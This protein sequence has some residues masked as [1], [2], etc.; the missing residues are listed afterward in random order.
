MAQKFTIPELAAA[1]RRREPRLAGVDDYALAKMVLERRPDLLQVLE[2]SEPRRPLGSLYERIGGRLK[3]DLNLP[4]QAQGA[5]QAIHQGLVNI[6]EHGPSQMPAFL[7]ALKQYA[8]PENAIGDILAS[9]I[10]GQGGDVAPRSSGNA[11]LRTPAMG[12][13]FMDM[14]TRRGPG[15]TTAPSTAPNY[16]LLDNLRMRFERQKAAEDPGM[17]DTGAKIREVEDQIKTA[18]QSQWGQAYQKLG[19]QTEAGLNFSA[20]DLEALKKKYGIG[21]V[22]PPSK[23][24]TSV[25]SYLGEN[26]PASMTSGGQVIEQAFGPKTIYPSLRAWVESH[27][28]KVRDV[29]GGGGWE[30][31]IPWTNREAGTK[32][33]TWEKFTNMEEARRALG[34]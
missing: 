17:W 10:M 30:V 20:G 24:G 33:S 14:S 7:Q 31:E 27:G 25:G 1:V 34:Y 8:K 6:R 5:A 29:H 16:G 9:I 11:P 2:T 19:K 26:K 21:E 22:I 28:F 18:E 32:G 23:P 15:N 12:E 13:D 3:Q 4:A